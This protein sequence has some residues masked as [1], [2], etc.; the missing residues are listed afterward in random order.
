[1]KTNVSE[2]TFQDENGRDEFF[3][4]QVAD[5]VIKLLTAD[6]QVSPM[7]IDGGWGTGKTEFCHKLINK[8]R[9]EHTNYRIV[10]VDAFKADHADNP[11]MTVLAAVLELLPEGKQREGLIKKALPVISYGLKTALK[12]SV[13][14][15]LRRNA[16]DISDE[17][18]EVL[19]ESAEKGIDASI[20]ILLK[21]HEKA[22]ESLDALQAI[23][24]EIAAESPIVLFIDELD[25]CRPDF[26][27]QM[28]EVIKHTFDVEGVQFVLVT[29]TKQLK[30][31]INH[32]YGAL[33]D[34][35]R[36][37]DK[38]LKFS[39]QLPDFVLDHRKNYEKNRILA[40]ADH[41]F[42]L[43]LESAILNKTSL[44][45][46]DGGVFIFSE[47]IISINV[48]SL[49]EV[50]TFVRYLEIYH[51]L[52]QE[53]VLNPKFGYQL[54]HIFGI[55]LFVFFPDVALDVQ[56]NRSDARKIA[57][58]LGFQN[59]LPSYELSRDN[60]SDTDTIAVLLTQES[61]L[62]REYYQM[63]EQEQVKWKNAISMLFNGN[64]RNNEAY[65]TIRA[66]MLVLRLGG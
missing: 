54:L 32:C 33:V 30:A 14:H 45:N 60:D 4:E 23:L 29:N 26:S 10:Y 50:E 39:F 18:G 59:N 25:R 52:S 38:F 40:A 51:S 15:I 64:L 47:E 11:L 61:D 8:F 37:L 34:S 46:R 48:L 9:K 28:L 27:V 66:A 20:E 43:I 3:R 21:E 56:Q 13:S 6:I 22:K 41:F 65:K 16:D 17:W 5:K 1:M 55:F 49:R 36:Y 24:T 42:N 19:K 31:A 7:V 12:A 2:L 57:A 58:L 35:Q 63:A 44:A 53:L 62:N